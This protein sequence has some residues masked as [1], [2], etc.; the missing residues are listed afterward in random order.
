MRTTMHQDLIDDIHNS[1]CYNCSNCYIVR[2]D[3]M[4]IIGRCEITKEEFAERFFITQG[5]YCT[6]ADNFVPY[7]ER[8]ENKDEECCKNYKQ[9]K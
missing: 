4:Y 1:I 7:C 5:K 9:K 2:E 6:H 3:N 8:P